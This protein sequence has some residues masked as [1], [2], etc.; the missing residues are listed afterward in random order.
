MVQGSGSSVQEVS[1]TCVMERVL[2]P[3][4]S[5]AVGC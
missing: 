3:N 1:K 5:G 2:K 4:I